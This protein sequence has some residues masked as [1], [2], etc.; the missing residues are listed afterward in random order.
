MGPL[1][2]AAAAGFRLDRPDAACG[3]L[4]RGGHGLVHGL[5]LAAFYK[6][7]LPAIAAHQAGQLLARNAG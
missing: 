7:G 4:H 3:F 5:W 2:L 1:G 6:Q